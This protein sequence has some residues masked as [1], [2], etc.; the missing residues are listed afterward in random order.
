ME[1]LSLEGMHSVLW[2]EHHRSVVHLI[3]KRS[4]NLFVEAANFRTMVWVERVFIHLVLNL[5]SKIL[6]HLKLRSTEIGSLH[7]LSP[8]I[9]QLLMN[10]VRRDVLPPQHV[11]LLKLNVL[12]HLWLHENLLG[13]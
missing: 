12:V 7:I 2:P 8:S 10:V 11:W 3:L 9:V 6:I 1:I 4:G 13:I 5:L